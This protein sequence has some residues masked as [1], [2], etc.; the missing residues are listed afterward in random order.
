MKKRSII[1]AAALLILAGVITVDSSP[2]RGAAS[3]ITGSSS[4]GDLSESFSGIISYAEEQI[5]SLTGHGSQKITLESTGEENAGS[6]YTSASANDNTGDEA[7][8]NSPVVNNAESFYYYD[9]LN[10]KERVLYD[11]MLTVARKPWTNEYGATLEIEEDPSSD[12]FNTTFHRAYDALLYDHPE[13]F[14]IYMNKSNIQFSYYLDPN[15]DGYYSVAFHLTDVYKDYEKDMAAFNEAADNIL[16]TIDL[17]WSDAAKALA[18][19][20]R[21][22]DL[23]TYKSGGLE[24]NDLAH[25][26][27]GAFVTD[28]TETA[29]SAVC[30]GYAFA[31]E[32]L[33]QQAGVEVTVVFGRAGSPD[34]I[35]NHAWNLIKLDGDWYE[36]DTTW[37]DHELESDS[38]NEYSEMIQNALDDEDFVKRLSHYMFMLTTEE[39]SSFNPEDY[40]NYYVYETYS[41]KV[42]FLSDSTHIRYTA[43]ES[44]ETGDYITDLAPAAYGTYYSYEYMIGN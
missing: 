17:T 18:L 3:F 24:A 1:L 23:V 13:L 10:E 11:E 38:S 4:S 36:V 12:S 15:A 22:L 43:D 14:W 30:D 19:H 35:E 29:N 26:A 44:E 9:Q 39:I 28:S 40:G 34:S 33:L 42:T 32:Y 41:G 16:S 7:G 20:D 5:R 8:D 21:L 6:F 2:L 25:T 37:D 27:F 31:Y